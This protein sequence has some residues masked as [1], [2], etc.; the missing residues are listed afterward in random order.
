MKNGLIL[1]ILLAFF[2]PAVYGNTGDSEPLVIKGFYLGMSKAEVQQ[3]FELFK[4]NQTAKYVS[5]MNERFRTSIKLDNDFSSMG[6]KIDIFYNIKGKVNDITFQYK[7]VDILFEATEFT[8][9]MFM[10]YISEKYELPEMKFKDQGFVKSWIYQNKKLNY[11]I[12]IDNNKNL[13]LQNI[14]KK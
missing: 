4:E 11:K 5:I 14:K 13:R 7:T 2:V 10:Q 12:S 3:I 9:E 6:N 8:A 1:V